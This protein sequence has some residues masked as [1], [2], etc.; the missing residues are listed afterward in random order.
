MR[1]DGRATA[2]SPWLHLVVGPEIVAVLV[3]AHPLVLVTELAAQQP[4][5]IVGDAPQPLFHRLLRFL[6]A[7]Q[8]LELFF[9]QLRR[10]LPG[11]LFGLLGRAL[12]LFLQRPHVFLAH[13]VF[14]LR[15][16]LFAGLALGLR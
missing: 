2:R 8:R 1:D 7:A 4:A 6:L 15:R 16:I 9:A 11:L 12:Q 5:G 3:A 13:L 10:L 14:T